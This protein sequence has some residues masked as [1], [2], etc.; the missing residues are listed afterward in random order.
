M[1]N[2]IF[3]FSVLMFITN[4]SFSQKRSIA[5]GAEPGELYLT[6]AW[7]GIYDPIYGP[8]AYDTIRSAV[9][10]ITENGNKLT[11]QYDADYFGNPMNEMLPNY[12]LSDATPGVLYT[13]SHYFKNSYPHT[14]LWVSFDHGKNWI[15]RE[16]NTGGV[17]YI[18]A[19]FK[20][21]LFKGGG[22]VFK[23]LDYGQTFIQE[24]GAYFCHYC[25]MGWEE[26]EVFSIG[27]LQS[28]KGILYHTHNFFRTYTEIPIDSQFVFG[29]LW[30]R[31]P[32]VYRGGLHGEVYVSSMFPE[33]NSKAAY[34]VSFSADTGHTFRHV[35][36]S[37]QFGN[38][39]PFPVFMSDRESGVFYIVKSYQIE[40]F[41]PWGHH[42]KVC[43]EYYRDYGETLV[44]T[45]C[46]DL[47][48]NYGKSCEAVNDLVSEKCGN[49]CVLLT[50]SEPES[51]LPVEE[52]W[53]Y[54]RGEEEKRRKGEEEKSRM[55]YELVG[56]TKGTTFLDENL[57]VG[58]YEYYVIAHY[59]M[60]CVADSSN[61]VTEIINI[62]EPC[63][64]VNNLGSEKLDNNTVLLTWS[65]PE[66][67]LQIEGYNVFR[68]NLLQNSVL[69]TDTVY[70]DENLPNGTYEYYV[71]AHYEMGCVADSSN[72]VKVEIDLGVKE[73]NDLE[74]VKV[75]P[76]PT[77]STVTIETNDFSK[78][79]IYNIFGQLLQTAKTQVVDVSTFN[80]GVYFF[81]IF[82]IEGNSITKRVVVVR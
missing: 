62:E 18:T 14:A 13:V 50:W 33:E 1:R 12:I 23:S 8:P 64:P 82:D 35:Y 40:D 30:S 36:V 76:N 81:K 60:G 53:V 6:G 73:I 29:Q 38:Q 21:L 52:Y 3:F 10:R 51:S 49:S 45:Y 7:Y 66:S 79:E 34:K 77:F 48:K 26:Q 80:A 41:N 5:R 37:E 27:A 56:V 2:I 19:I 32:D 75:Y 11:I 65:E 47:H 28:Y 16:E 58:E 55:A 17:G 67:N 22:G 63:E 43:I 9:Y 24:F 61:H 20:K 74:G 44:D 25:D 68:N 71:V 59:E 78:V 54:R 57:E 31:F 4:I 70:L 69:L 46:H 42:T 72:H 15:F 39:G